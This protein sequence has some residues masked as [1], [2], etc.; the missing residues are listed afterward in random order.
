[1]QVL[2][3]MEDGGIQPSM[4]MYH[5]I[6]SFAQKSAGIQYG[7]TIQECVGKLALKGAISI[8]VA[9]YLCR[10]PLPIL[11]KKL[12]K[13]QKTEDLFCCMLLS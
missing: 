4:K 12:K 7:A 2:Q 5:D 9:Y 10:I 13:P 1:M 8:S 3:W 11:T 6:L